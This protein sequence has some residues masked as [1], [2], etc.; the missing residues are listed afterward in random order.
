MRK[1][2]VIYIQTSEKGIEASVRILKGNKDG[3]ILEHEGHKFA[4]PIPAL[5]DSLEELKKFYSGE[6]TTAETSAIEE[7]IDEVTYGE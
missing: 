2:L 5:L 1:E 3:V 7:V 4:V 6:P